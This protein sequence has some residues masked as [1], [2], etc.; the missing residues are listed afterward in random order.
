MLNEAIREKLAQSLSEVNTNENC[1]S[2][3]EIEGFLFAIA[4]T[5]EMIPPTDWLPIIFDED[6][7]DSDFAGDINDLIGNL[8][9]AYNFY[10]SLRLK[11]KLRFPYNPEEMT[12]ENELFETI[13][14]WSTGFWNGLSLRFDFWNSG[15]IAKDMG[16]GQDPIQAILKILNFIIDPDY[17]DQPTFDAFVQNMPPEITEDNARGYVVAMGILLLPSMVE[18][19]Q[20]FAA[21]M[22]SRSRRSELNK[23]TNQHVGRNDPCPCGSGKKFKKCCLM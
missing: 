10:N 13:I 4:I 7:T 8:L 20:E 11:G 14:S 23:F 5:P 12:Q 16:D 19:L 3:T 17:F 9:S 15:I 21:E 22:D 18:T 2:V 6:M 1:F